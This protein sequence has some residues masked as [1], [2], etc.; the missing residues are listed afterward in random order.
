[1]HTC[2]HAYM[3]TCI[4]AYINTYIHKYLHPY[5]TNAADAANDYATTQFLLTVRAH[6][7]LQRQNFC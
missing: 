1:M 7:P 5:L 4:Q 6:Q 3:Q 2:I